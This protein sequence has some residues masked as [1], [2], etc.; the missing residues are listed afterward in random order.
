M[1]S[2]SDPSPVREYFEP[3]VRQSLQDLLIPD[4]GVGGYLADVL[5]RGAF[6]PAPPTFTDRLAEIARAWNVAGPHFDPR[7]EVTL[8]QELADY[9]L[10][11]SGFF[12]DVVRDAGATRVH[13]RL[14]RR[15]YRFVAEHRRARGEAD[16]PLYR[17]LADRFTTY[18]G[19]LTYLRE[20]YVAAPFEPR[21]LGSS[22]SV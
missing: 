3:L 5:V 19:V 17:A 7:R 22:V 4:D 21:W 11:M 20:V 8:R 18:A 10:L 1:A 6:I 15:A 16:A 2:A 14:G 12:W 9:A 13:T